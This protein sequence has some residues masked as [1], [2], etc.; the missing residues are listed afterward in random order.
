MAKSAQYTKQ[1]IA[2]HYAVAHPDEYYT[3]QW[4]YFQSH[5]NIAEF[6]SLTDAAKKKKEQARH[7]TKAAKKT[8]PAA[9]STSRA[10]DKDESDDDDDEEESEEEDDG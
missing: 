3:F 1:N 6:P 7:Q 2:Q 10:G 9:A 5:L 8:P 4:D